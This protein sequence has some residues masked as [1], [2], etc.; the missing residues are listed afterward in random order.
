MSVTIEVIPK[1]K[2]FF[3]YVLFL[4]FSDDFF[5]IKSLVVY[6]TYFRELIELIS[7]FMLFSSLN[8]RHLVNVL[9]CT[10][11]WLGFMLLCKSASAMFRWD[12]PKFMSLVRVTCV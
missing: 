4:Q 5:P 1:V 6:R 12:G 3:E 10:S 2:K 9:E 8:F 7:V 11:Y